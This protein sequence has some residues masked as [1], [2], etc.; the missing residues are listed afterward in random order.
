MIR[1]IV[2]VKIKNKKGKIVTAEASLCDYWGRV[3][4]SKKYTS[5]K[6]KTFRR[7]DK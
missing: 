1:K 2:Y 5:S 3:K 4:G 6:N 7:V